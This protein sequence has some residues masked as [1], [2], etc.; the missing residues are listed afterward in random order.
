MEILSLS[1]EELSKLFVSAIPVGFLVG[2][3]PMIIGVVIH[4]IV[5]ILKRA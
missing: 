1:V 5:G 4:G 3:T 2:C